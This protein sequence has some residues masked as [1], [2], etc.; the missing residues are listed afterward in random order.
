M[1]IQ[2]AEKVL[3]GSRVVYI[4]PAIR[5]I[6]GVF[7]LLIALGFFFL[8][9]LD[10]LWMGLALFLAI[11]LLGS[12]LTQFCLMAWS[13]RHL[14]LRSEW[15]ELKAL[16]RAHATAQTRAS[17]LDTLNIL[18]EVIVEMAPDG[19]LIWKSDRWSELFG[20]D[21]DPDFRKCIAEGDSVIFDEMVATLLAGK[22]TQAKIHFSGCHGA[23]KGHWL[24]GRFTLS[25]DSEGG[26][27]LRGILRDITDTYEANLVNAHKATH[28]ELTKLPNRT[29][30]EDRLDQAKARAD[31]QKT[32]LAVLFI[33]LDHF[34]QVNDTMG[35]HVG[36]QVLVSVAQAL[37]EGLRP[38]DTVARW[39][40]DE[41]VALV[42]DLQNLDV[43]RVIAD[44]L[45]EAA[46]KK[47]GGDAASRVTFSIGAATYPNDASSVGDLLLKADKALYLAKSLGRDNV[48]FASPPSGLPQHPEDCR[49]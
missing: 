44:G 45:L 2:F 43:V 38:S 34:K 37:N 29:L 11:G 36:D 23:S 3:L 24:E 21:G 49:T 22:E 30:F 40:G 16:E 9:G 33:D 1:P 20:E 27:V 46:R 18:N 35:H 4:E 31:R 41:F 39:G 8:P 14:G 7:V 13:L 47:L 28:D 10:T 25:R 32:A 48:Q 5:L 6:V 26:V 19:S 17:Y 42:P 15:D 12:G